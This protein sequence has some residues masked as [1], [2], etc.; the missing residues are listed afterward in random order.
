[1][2]DQ[3]ELLRHHGFTRNV[4]DLPT[5]AAD[6]GLGS[7]KARRARELIVRAPSKQF[8]QPIKLRRLP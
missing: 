5:N 8:I 7:P 2:A 6:A 4:I 3:P 1:M